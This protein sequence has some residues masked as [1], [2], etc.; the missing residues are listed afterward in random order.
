MSFSEALSFDDVLLR[1]RYSDIVSRSEV[2]LSAKL[3][4]TQSLDIPIITAPMDTIT[5]TDMAIGM[6]NLGG[7]GIVHRY[8]DIDVQAGIVKKIRNAVDEHGIIAAAIGVTGDFEERAQELHN[9][10]ADI[11]CIDVAHGHHV[12]MESALRILRARFGG[13]KHLM[14]GNIATHYGFRDL[15]H[16]G[17]SSIR[18]GI[19]GGSIC[20]TRIKT[21]HGVPTWQSVRDCNDMRATLRHAN[22]PY[23]DVKIIADGG[24]KNSGDIVKALAAG[25]D[26]VMVGSLVAGTTETPGPVLKNSEGELC[27]VYRGMASMQAQIDWRGR[28]SSLEGVSSHVPVAGPVENTIT[29]LVRGIK[30]GLSYTGARTIGE[31]QA[32]AE[33]IKQSS[34]GAF[35]SGP[36]IYERN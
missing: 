15:A 10:G 17:A 30:S 31:L 6:S 13:D 16:W 8:N 26:M 14:A 4:P 36:H 21:G 3:S 2:D 23:A 28:V 24:I 20:S 29:G 12:T 35:E 22:H 25:A 19:G 34:A 33:F 7:L 9:A 27:K 32:T 11:L 18:V 5:E 1:P